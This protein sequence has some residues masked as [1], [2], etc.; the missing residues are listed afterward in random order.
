MIFTKTGISASRGVRGATATTALRKQARGSSVDGRQA[1]S[2]H[3]A[4]LCSSR[5]QEHPLP[6]AYR[7]SHGLIPQPRAELFE[8]ESVLLLVGGQKCGCTTKKDSL[9]HHIPA[10]CQQQA[11]GDGCWT[12]INQVQADVFWGSDANYGTDHCGPIVEQSNLGWGELEAL[13]STAD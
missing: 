12:Y 5:P 6:A 4:D 11:L 8:R 7:S 3:R 1:R 13:V 10:G 9:T 2:A